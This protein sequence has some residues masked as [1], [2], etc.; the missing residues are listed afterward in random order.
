[1]LLC[2][3]KV[4]QGYRQFF[5]F[6][7]VAAPDFKQRGYGSERPS[8]SKYYMYSGGPGRVFRDTGILCIYLKG[9]RILLKTMKNGIWGIQS[10][11]VN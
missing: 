4:K 7:H 8:D 3:K 2:G 10:N 9:Y 11:L 6:S 5:A 1:M